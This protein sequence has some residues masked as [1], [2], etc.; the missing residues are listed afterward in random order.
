MELHLYATL[1][2]LLPFSESATPGRIESLLHQ[3]ARE[4]YVGVEIQIA[5]LLLIGKERFI[6][7]LTASQLR[8]IGKVYSSGGPS[9]C[10]HAAGFTQT[11]PPSGRS[12]ESHI[13]VWNASVRE[14]CEPPALKDLLTSISSQ[15]GRDYFHRNHDTESHAF[16][17]NA[18]SLEKALN[19]RIHHETHRHRL[20]FSPFH[21]VETLEAFP[22]LHL[23][24]DLSHYAVVCEAACGDEE[25]EEAILK[26]IPAIGHIHLRVGYNEGPQVQDPAAQSAASQLAGHARW[27]AHTWFFAR[28]RG[29]TKIVTATPEFLLPPYARD[30]DDI[31]ASNKFIAQY[32]RGLFLASE[33]KEEIEEYIISTTNTTTSLNYQ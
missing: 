2:P 22:N 15:S 24:G 17:T 8:F 31:T 1:V 27:W 29:D 28:Q 14:C 18:V 21:A 32:A 5:Q 25:L 7:A 23:L 26:L 20:L 6:A 13:D 12:V 4:G 9:A 10:P 33:T 3:L 11:H 16:F 30:G 19:V